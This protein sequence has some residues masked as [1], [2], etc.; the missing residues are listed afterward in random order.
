MKDM[1]DSAKH[2]RDT[3]LQHVG[4]ETKI[5]NAVVPPLFM[6]SLFVFPTQAEFNEAAAN[7]LDNSGY[8]SRV[9]NP[10]LEVA[11]KKIA[12]L[13]GAEC[14]K[15]VGSGM[16]AINVAIMSCARAG[17]HIVAVDTCYGPARDLITEYL[18]PLGVSHTFVDGTCAEEVIDAIRPETTLVYLESPS[19]MLFRLQNLREIAAA[20]REKGVTT[21]IDNTYSTPLFQN[22]ISLGVD[23]VLHSAS[24]YLNGHSDIVA[25]A[26]CSSRALMDRMLRKEICLFGSI[27][28]PYA[29]WL[30]TRGLRTLKLRLQ[31]HQIA[32]NEVA[33][34]LEEQDW[35]ARVHHVGLRSYPQRDLY[36][37]QMRGTG[38][39]LSFEPANQDPVA[40][41]RFVDNLKLFGLGVSWGG[42]ESLVV[43]SI[44][45]PMHFK[46]P[47][48]LVRV[49][50]GLEDV[51]DMIQDLDQAAQFAF[52]GA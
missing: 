36:M 37:R 9:G 13:E 19:S 41:D 52:Q 8:Y 48:R 45:K 34:W 30:L 40:I 4:E 7:P 44:Q 28:N 20:C 38:G 2:G 17:A 46:E 14:C 23:I 5:K 33:G 25:G 3:L 18:A 27:L 24:K 35:V 16:A 31:A 6:N 32:G 12:M 42:H 11:E 22:P 15:L 39:L 1:G 47:R 21:V 49:F 50:C 29:G 10:S 43:Q 51:E 26:I